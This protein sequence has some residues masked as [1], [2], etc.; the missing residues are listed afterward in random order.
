MKAWVLPWCAVVGGLT[1]QSRCQRDSDD[2]G[3]GEASWTSDGRRSDVL[4]ARSGRIRLARPSTR[5]VIPGFGGW[6]G[7][8]GGPS[9]AITLVSPTPTALPAGL[10]FTCLP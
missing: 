3:Q 10:A 6:L 5:R 9:M 8:H 2:L 4:V 1:E 7:A